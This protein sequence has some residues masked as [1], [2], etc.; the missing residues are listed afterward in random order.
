MKRTLVLMRHADASNSASR[1]IDRPLSQQ[2]RKEAGSAKVFLAA[3]GIQPDHAL[4]SPA[5][6]TRMT[7][8][9]LGTGVD[10]QY[11]DAL[12]HAGSDTILELLSTVPDDK[13]CVIVVGHAPGVPALVHDLTD[14]ES[15]DD[16][17]WHKVEHYYPTATAAVF[18]L[19]VDGW[20]DVEAGTGR[21][22]AAHRVLYQ[23]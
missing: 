1:D 9:A 3:K 11:D 21:L 12:Y 4:V 5:M 13:A 17:A 23:P 6:R 8:E 20:G 22:V 2:G 10:P 15:S 16:A 18:E 19:D 14:Q 7:F